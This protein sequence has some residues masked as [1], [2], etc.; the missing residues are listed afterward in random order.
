TEF[1]IQNHVAAPGTQ[2]NLHRVR[3]LI[4]SAKNRLTALLAMYNL[5]CVCHIQLLQ[6]FVDVFPCPCSVAAAIPQ[7]LSANN[8][9]PSTTANRLPTSF[10]PRA[11]AA[12][13]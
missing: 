9:R 5:L 2:R 6:D 3:Q 12:L 7:Q 4:D 1:L 11:G 10:L 13:P 8:F